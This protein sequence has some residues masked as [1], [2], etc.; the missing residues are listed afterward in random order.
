MR[1]VFRVW[2]VLVVFVVSSGTGRVDALSRESLVLAHVHLRA[3]QSLLEGATDVD[4]SSI[5]DMNSEREPSEHIVAML[6]CAEAIG[7]SGTSV[8]PRSVAEAFAHVRIAR[9][10]VESDRA[11]DMMLH[12][13]AGAD[14]LAW[15]LRNEIAWELVRIGEVLD[16]VAAGEEPVTETATRRPA[17]GPTTWLAIEA[18]DR[19]CEP[20]TYPTI[21]AALAL[22]HA[23]G[24][25]ETD[26]ASC[27]TVTCSACGCPVGFYYLALV[28][29]DDLM[30][31]RS[32]GWVEMDLDVCAAIGYYP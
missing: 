12:R 15:D 26:T 22:L 13:L 10:Y 2:I 16:A 19:Q 1:T 11:S 25:H 28:R 24:V 4:I 17:E 27:G 6:G 5:G 8:Q 3:A 20:L 31:A 7:S 23:Q 21:E 18:G 14:R 30:A 29:D 9:V 32:A